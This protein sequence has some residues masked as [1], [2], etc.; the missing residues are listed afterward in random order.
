M[1]SWPE[2]RQK[3][4]GEFNADLL[5][6][7]LIVPALPAAL[8]TFLSRAQSPDVS[9]AEL[10][11]IIAS[12]AGLTTDL[13]RCVNSCAVGLR[14]KASSCQQALA[15]LG[16]KRTKMHLMA[17][18]SQRLTNPLRP[19]RAFDLVQHAQANL[20]RA[21]F[22]QELAKAFKVDEDLAFSA[23]LLS[24][25]LL[26]GLAVEYEDA[27]KT[28]ITMEF[29]EKPQ[30]REYE[31]KALGWNHAVATAHVLL[32]W[33][34]PEDLVCSVF[35]H[36]DALF[37][38]SHPEF[39]NTAMLPVALASLLPDPLM[40][41]PLGL[42]VLRKWDQFGLR[43]D[44]VKIVEAVDRRMEQEQEGPID[45][46]PLVVRIVTDDPLPKQGQVIPFAASISA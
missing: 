27:Y 2:I 44:I 35:F 6:S 29:F 25:C 34:F 10:A 4:L 16:I 19:V 28:F 5:P 40:Q 46:I 23:A 11:A 7:R 21:I 17:A 32:K 8:T 38:L 9:I 36:H 13:L 3:H 39:K 30:L 15:L 37:L 1:L 14:H 43:G 45:R 12:D 42:G 31:Q 22:A 18:T 26:P 33:G 20:E 41:V 24:D